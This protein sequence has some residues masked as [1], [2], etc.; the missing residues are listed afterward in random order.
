M[1]QENHQQQNG[2]RPA[3][4]SSKSILREAVRFVRRVTQDMHERNPEL[5]FDGLVCEVEHE[6]VGLYVHLHDTTGGTHQHA[7]LHSQQDEPEWFAYLLELEDER[8]VE[9]ALKRVLDAVSDGLSKLEASGLLRQHGFVDSPDL[10]AYKTDAPKGK[11]P[12]F[13]FEM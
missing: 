3:F 5:A 11:G 2:D 9:A 13:E 4:P 7:Q 8:I 1:K 10:C 12:S 6:G